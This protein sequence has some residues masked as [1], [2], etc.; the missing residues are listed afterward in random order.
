MSKAIPSPD[1]PKEKPKHEDEYHVKSAM[2]D[3]LR[4]EEHK[5]DPLLM[6]AIAKH[7]GK[8]AKAINS[9]AGLRKKAHEASKKK[10]KIF[11]QEEGND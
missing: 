8:K 7:A 11:D 3:L 4:A 9:I 6:A 1:S 5:Q 2:D 10:G